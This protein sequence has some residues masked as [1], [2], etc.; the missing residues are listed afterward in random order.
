MVRILRTWAAWSHPLLEEP[1]LHLWV[2]VNEVMTF[3]VGHVW[4]EGLHAGNIHG[5]RVLKLLQER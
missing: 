4:A 5:G 2:C 3:T 1:K